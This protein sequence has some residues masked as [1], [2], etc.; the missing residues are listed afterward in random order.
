MVTSD[1]K[2]FCV[3]TIE[4]IDNTSYYIINTD[5]VYMILDVQKLLNISDTKVFNIFGFNVW[6][7]MQIKPKYTKVSASNTFRYINNTSNFVDSSSVTVD[8]ASGSINIKASTSVDLDN[9]LDSI[10]QPIKSINGVPIVGNKLL[11]RTIFSDA[12]NII[13]EQQDY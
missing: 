13:P 5:V 3:A 2:R 11:V 8:A 1:S 10:Q 9:Y 4:H 12:V 6:Y 7:P